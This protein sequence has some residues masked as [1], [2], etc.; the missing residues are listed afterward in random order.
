MRLAAVIA[1]G[2]VCIG[3]VVLMAT[4]R[5]ASDEKP[6]SPGVARYHSSTQFPAG[7]TMWRINE[8]SVALAFWRSARDAQ[9]ERLL[10]LDEATISLNESSNVR[11]T[12]LRF[13]DRLR[14]EPMGHS[15]DGWSSLD[16][17]IT[18]RDRYGGGRT[19]GTVNVGDKHIVYVL[20][21]RQERTCV[22]LATERPADK[23]PASIDPFGGKPVSFP[24]YKFPDDTRL[25]VTVAAFVDG[26]GA[27]RQVTYE[28]RGSK[29]MYGDHAS[30]S[31]GFIGVSVEKH[32]DFDYIILSPKF[33]EVIIVP[34]PKP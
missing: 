18:V 3:S 7:V 8:S 28:L 32:K 30:S 31:R 24:T 21:D 23:V 5:C 33:F 15:H 26:G 6:D 20:T 2:L 29:Y 34:V 9:P 14:P 12:N 19:L 11:M 25:Y 4:A 1:G 27:A 22:V 17:L 13:E 16:G 10:T